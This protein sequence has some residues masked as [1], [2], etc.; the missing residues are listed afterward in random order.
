MKD[1]IVGSE[2][3]LIAKLRQLCQQHQLVISESALTAAGQHFALLLKWNQKIA[4]TTLTDPEIAAQRLYFES[5][6]ASQYIALPEAGFI[7]TGVDIGSGAGFPGILMALQHP[8]INFTLLESDRRKAAFLQEASY[9]LGLS[10]VKIIA[11]RFEQHLGQFDFVTARALEK[12]SHQIPILWKKYSIARQFIFFLNIS[13]AIEIMNNL[14]S[15]TTDWYFHNIPL[16]G[17]KSLCLLL[18]IRKT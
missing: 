2:Q 6:F 17:T 1:T 10:N 9:K 15:M 16:L 5:F 18:A 12:F 14:T 11:T 7:T 4:L 13:T 8:T 3:T